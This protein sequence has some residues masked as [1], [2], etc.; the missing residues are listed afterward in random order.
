VH[1]I[2]VQSVDGSVVLLNDREQSHEQDS[3]DAAD[4]DREVAFAESIAAHDAGCRGWLGAD[5]AI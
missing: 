1:E 4:R 2:A 3:N 5:H